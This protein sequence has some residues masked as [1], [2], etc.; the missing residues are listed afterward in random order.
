MFLVGKNFKKAA[1]GLDIAT[2]DTTDEMIQYLK[3]NPLKQQTILVKG[4]NSIHLERLEE[5]L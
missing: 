3:S 4:S 5:F 2:F 1:E